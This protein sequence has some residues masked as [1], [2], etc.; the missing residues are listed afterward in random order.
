MALDDADFVV[1]TL[2]EPER[3]VVRWLAIGDDAA[4]IALDHGRELFVWREVLIA[5]L[6]SYVAAATGSLYWRGR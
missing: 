6:R 1:E 4:P 5:Q 3:D 2:D